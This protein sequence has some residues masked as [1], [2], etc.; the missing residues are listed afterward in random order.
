[1]GC[2]LPSI[3][4][5]SHEGRAIE[6]AVE[7]GSFV[8]HGAPVL[9]ARGGSAVDEQ[10]LRR[11]LM[12]A[13]GRTVTQDPAFA[14]RCTVDVAIRALSPAVNDPTSALEGLDALGG[15]LLRLGARQLGVSAVLDA[16]GTVRLVLPTAGWDA[17]VDLTLT[18]IRRYGCETPQVARRM[19]ALIDDLMAR[20]PTALHAPLERHRALLDYDLDRV[21]PN[22]VDRDFAAH[23]DRMGIGGQIG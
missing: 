17:M 14:L 2:S 20:V 5:P 10:A 12:F 8:A 18:E 15:M 4:R 16:E 13:K 3:A 22:P 1:M 19:R 9:H 21:Y 23:P 11:S 7:V 6:V